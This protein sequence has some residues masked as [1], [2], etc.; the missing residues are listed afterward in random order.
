MSAP[1]SLGNELSMFTETRK[2]MKKH[3]SSKNSQDS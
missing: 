3:P 1:A 2:L